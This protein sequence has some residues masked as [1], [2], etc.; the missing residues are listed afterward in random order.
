MKILIISHALIRAES[1]IRWKRLVENYSDID[2]RIL[3][4]RLWRSNWFEGSKQKYSGLNINTERYEVIPVVTTSDKNWYYYLIPALRYHLASY[5]PDIIYCIHEENIFVLHQA[6]AFRRIFIPKAK[7]VYF[8]MD[9]SD[10][11]SRPKNRN[12]KEIIKYA[13]SAV[14]WKNVV[15][16]T[17]GA[18]VHFPE[19]KAKMIK[20]GYR[21]PIY[22]QTQIGVDENQFHPD[23]EAGK[24]VKD[25][26]GLCGFVVGFVGRLIEEKG[27]IDL[28][29]SMKN[30][31]P[32][33]Q[34]LIVGEGPCREYVEE[35]AI[36]NNFCERLVMTGYVPLAEV[37][38]YMRAMDVFVLGSKAT[39]KWT[40]TFP[41]VVAQAMATRIPTIV[42]DSG[43]LPYQ[44]GI[45][46]GLI[47]RAGDY[48]MLRKI[49]DMLYCNE[50]F[51]EQEAERLFRR[52][53]EKFCIDGINEHFYLNIK[54]IVG[55]LN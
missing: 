16:G 52:A 55:K 22:I 25:Q 48:V 41:L 50:E 4:P 43:A 11:I 36:E 32:D 26:L 14:V 18:F 23:R 53:R 42:S 8:S 28:L 49:I 24:K 45:K 20:Y 17:D 31:P 3:V 27:L 38:N 12:I 19:I 51:R 37:P 39:P 54:Q 1:Q 7:L 10:R 46:E 2:V 40:D 35:W 34:L 5:N 13:Y 33:W 29:K 44:V 9:V 15:T 47:F 21:Q 6:I 30:A